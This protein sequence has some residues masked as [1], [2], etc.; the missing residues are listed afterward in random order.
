MS[1]YTLP[2]GNRPFTFGSHS[3]S[4]PYLYGRKAGF[5]NDSEYNLFLDYELGESKKLIE[6]HTSQ[7]VT[8]LALP[9]GDGAGDPDIIAAADRNGYKF[10]RTSIYGAIKNPLIDLYSI[11][12]LPILSDTNSDEI[13]Y[14]L[15]NK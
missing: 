12:S 10:I 14:Y 11:P 1:H 15:S 7:A 9:F 3:Y 13:G 2:G 5:A 4:H 8:I 6:I